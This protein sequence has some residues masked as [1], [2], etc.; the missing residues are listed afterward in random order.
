VIVIIDISLYRHNWLDE[1]NKIAT[2]TIPVVIKNGD[3]N[4]ITSSYETVRNVVY[5][6]GL[7]DANV[8]QKITIQKFERDGCSVEREENIERKQIEEAI[9]V[10][11]VDTIRERRY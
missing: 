4:D 6:I 5:E 3:W 10:D 11:L 1:P 8:C 9:N 2:I 7:E